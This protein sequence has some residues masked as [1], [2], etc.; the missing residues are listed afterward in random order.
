MKLILLEDMKKLGS[1]G[2]E[3]NVKDGYAR[4]YLIPRKLAV[5]ATS[6][7]LRILEQKKKANER[8]EAERKTECEELA[9]K[10]KNTSCTI[11]VEAG[12]EDRLFGAVT[13]EMISESL[14]SEGVEIDRKKILLEEPLKKLGVYDVDIKLH[15]EVKTQVRVWIV[16]K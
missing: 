11:S 3:V 15:P 4:N 2:D 8:K 13:S 14:A 16:K 1:A 7:A 9:E 6:G 12:E 10:I 5:E